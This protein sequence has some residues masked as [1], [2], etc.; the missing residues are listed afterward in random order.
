MTKASFLM[1]WN[2]ARF[3]HP[4]SDCDIMKK[5]ITDVVAVLDLNTKSFNAL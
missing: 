2:I 5:N 4:Y 3:R 1:P